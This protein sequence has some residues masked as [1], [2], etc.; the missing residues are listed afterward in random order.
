MTISWRG[1]DVFMPIYEYE[2][3]KCG[4][5]FSLTLAMEEHEK[6]KVRCPKCKSQDAKHIIASVFVTTSKKS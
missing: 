5:G 1:K 6:K 4:H 2:C 3:K